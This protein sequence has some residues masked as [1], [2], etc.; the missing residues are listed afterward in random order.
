MRDKQRV[1]I[2]GWLL[3]LALMCAKWF[4]WRKFYTQHVHIHGGSQRVVDNK[5]SV[6]CREFVQEPKSLK[7]QSKETSTLQSLNH[8]EN[9]TAAFQHMNQSYIVAF[10]LRFGAIEASSISYGS[11]FLVNQSQLMKKFNHPL[12]KL[13]LHSP[14]FKKG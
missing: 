4:L 9:L 1:E 10:I 13:Y 7:M 8:R 14:T 5:I 3:L 6:K 2:L 12:H 11:F